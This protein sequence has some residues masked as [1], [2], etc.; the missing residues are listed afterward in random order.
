MDF[1]TKNVN[2]NNFTRNFKSDKM[3][4]DYQDSEA[5][6]QNNYNANQL[7]NGQVVPNRSSS[8]SSLFPA[9][10]KRK[11][12]LTFVVGIVLLA[13]I[14]AVFASFA[15]LS[16]LSHQRVQIR[17]L[18]NELDALKAENA[19]CKNETGSLGL[20]LTDCEKELQGAQHQIE[21]N[22]A[23][24]E[25]EKG[26]LTA[27]L[28]A[29]VLKGEHEKE[30]AQEKLNT[31]ESNKE[32]LS[33]RLEAQTTNAEAEKR[34]LR[35]KLNQ[36]E[37]EK[38]EISRSRDEAISQQ[39]AAERAAAEAAKSTSASDGG[40]SSWWPSSRSNGAEHIQSPQAGLFLSAMFLLLLLKVL[41][42][43]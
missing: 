36:C 43:E 3:A 35:E 12:V 24:C 7:N 20:Q 37:Q 29:E 9:Q 4:D 14:V 8:F 11:I 40:S 38:R 34:D 1:S 41:H 23:Q 13:G 2:N 19:L 21:I 32:D 18:Q 28:A 22:A 5:C 16:V 33:Q 17:N 10:S 39:R 27:K 25:L 30:I 26:N 6:L 15:M 42:V 31:C